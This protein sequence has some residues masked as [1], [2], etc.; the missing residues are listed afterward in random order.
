MSFKT[1]EKEFQYSNQE[2]RTIKMNTFS[3]AGYFVLYLEMA[4]YL[5]LLVTKGQINKPEAFLKIGIIVGAVLLNVIFHRRNPSWKQFKMILIWEYSAVYLMLSFHTSSEFLTIT[6]LGILSTFIAY[7]DTKLLLTAAGIFCCDYVLSI[8]IRYKMHL[9]EADIGLLCM[10]IMFIMCVYTIVRVGMI[11]KIF[12]DHAF[13]SIQVQKEKQESMLEHILGISKT[14]RSETEKSNEM[15]DGLVESTKT[16]S[17]SMR[18]IADATNLTA[19]NICQQ[20][21]MTQN[22]QEAIDETAEHSKNAVDVAM[23]SD[24]DLKNSIQIVKEL[25]NQAELIT[26]T[27]GK[28]TDSMTSLQS[29]T[30]AVE[31][32]TEIIFSI[33]SQTNLLALNASIESARAGEAGK[34]FAVVADQ[35]R[36]LSEQTRT[37]TEEITHIIQELN[38]NAEEVVTI[39]GES[40]KAADSQSA[41]ILDAARSFEKMDTNIAGLIEDIQEISARIDRLA[42]SNNHIVENISHLSATTQQ[43]TASA[44]QA[45]VL[46]EQNLELAQTT[47]EAIEMIETTTGDLDQYF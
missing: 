34:G 17:H 5:I 10:I 13:G 15:V 3:L 37:S 14:V 45:N 31:E 18:E 35:I 16:V 38:E 22:I 4:A 25:Q 12:N 39:I 19:E 46:S 30:K 28:V 27:N 32:I 43:V 26:K 8:I 29:R 41:M 33:S 36:E 47:K 23:D 21:S 7:F 24:R 11:A 9:I 2:Q 40:V 1:E 6:L 20:N 42:D 44:E